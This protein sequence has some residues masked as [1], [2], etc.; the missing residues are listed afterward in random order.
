MHRSPALWSVLVWFVGGFAAVAHAGS[1]SWAGKTIILKRNGNKIGNSDDNGNQVYVAKLT[2]IDYL[3]LGDKDGWLKV[4]HGKY[5]GWF[6]K[7]EAVL[8]EDA[9]AYFSTLIRSNPTNDQYYARRAAAYNELGEDDKA[10]ADYSQIIRLRPSEPDW[11]GN[12]GMFKR[13]RK[14]Y[15]GAISD[16]TRAI[17][18]DSSNANRY[19]TRGWTYAMAKEYDKAIADCTTALRMEPT[20]YL[21][22]N[23][24]GIAYTGR[25]DL[26]RAL[27]DFAEALRINP[28]HYYVYGNRAKVWLLKDQPDKALE[29]YERSIKANADIPDAYNSFAWF[30]ATSYDKRVRDGKR[31]LELAKKACAM[32]NYHVPTHLGTL[33]AAHAEVGQFDEAV[34]WQEKALQN[35]AYAGVN[36]AEA[37][38]R[39]A[40]YRDKKAYTVAEDRPKTPATPAPAETI[41][42]AK[43]KL[44]E[45]GPLKGWQEW[46]APDG[47][48]SVAFPESPR[49]QK[50]RVPSAVGN[51][52]NYGYYH[53]GVDAIYLA[54]YFDVPSDGLL[55]AEQVASSYATGRKGRITSQKAIKL[56]DVRGQEVSVQLPNGN[57]SRVRFYESGVRRFQVVVEGPA[58]AVN[59]AKATGF[60]DSFQVKR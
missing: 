54:G 39:L 30:L 24:R 44:I 20:S 14:D 59:S 53:E 7:N 58:N 42:T 6:D 33:A 10:L 5:E 32:S 55:K 28:S 22:Y 2:S 60:L 46:K 27:D 48:F 47:S 17:Q 50:Q 49:L 11:W 23:R 26:D 8:V 36:G 52:D 34:R 12:R 3:C 25:G 16:F 19:H 15:E 41:K 40:L 51:V 4:R 37:R 56:G 43:V 31:A 18:L 45:S 1:D 35:R 29:E 9:P 57:V 13:E 21:A 38:E